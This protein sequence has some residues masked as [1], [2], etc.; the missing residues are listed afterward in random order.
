M[1]GLHQALMQELGS[2][3]SMVI[4]FTASQFGEGT[5]TIALGFGLFL[6]SA[7]SPGHICVVEGNL[8]KPSFQDIYG[9]KFE[10]GLQSV[11]ERRA[12][13]EDV[14]QIEDIGGIALVP[15]EQTKGR[16]DLLTGEMA[17]YDFGEI[18]EEL[19]KKFRMIVLDSPPATPY[20]DAAI[21]AEFVDRVVF[22]VESN[23]TRSEVVQHALDRVASSGTT[24]LGVMLNKREFH[25]PSFIYRYL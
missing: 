15:A 4:Q 25:I 22:V 14:I 8:R 16:A 9:M 2:Q 24:I 7:Y 6:A 5:T 18:I 21:L 17:R 23:R 11:L 20:V 12:N 3:N 19:R 13:L 10:R 1:L